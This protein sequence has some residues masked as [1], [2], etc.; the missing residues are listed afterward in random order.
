[1]N[2]QIFSNKFK[3]VGLIIFLVCFVVPMLISIFSG[4]F[5][6]F[7]SNE[8]ESFTEKIITSP[9]SRWLEFFSMLGMLIYMLSKEKVEDD[10]INKL[11]LE[12]FQLTTLI[13]L[14]IGFILYFFN[15][16]L[17][18]SLSYFIF[19]FLLTFLIIFSFKKRS[20]L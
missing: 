18:F 16:N 6:P 13:G 1:M 17:E 2:F 8:H 12:S 15:R 5:H 10:Y 11:R 4:L 9:V 3:S 19:L 14:V 20:S 7:T